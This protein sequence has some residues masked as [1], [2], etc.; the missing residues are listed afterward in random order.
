M[1]VFTPEFQKR[2]YHVTNSF[3]VC[4]I[5]KV[6]NQM[7]HYGLKYLSWQHSWNIR[8]MLFADFIAQQSQYRSTMTSFV[9]ILLCIENICLFCLFTL[10][11]IWNRTENV[12]AFWA[13]NEQHLNLT[14]FLWDVIQCCSRLSR[15]ILIQLYLSPWPCASFS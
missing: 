12:Y 7:F 3:A 14:V 11:S 9:S 1:L 5:S 2:S 4:K 10:I 6:C 13:I 15:I 8:D